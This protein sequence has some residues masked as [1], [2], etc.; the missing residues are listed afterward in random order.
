ML[1]IPEITGSWLKRIKSLYYLTNN[2]TGYLQ[3]KCSPE[4]FSEWVL[5]T[6]ITSFVNISSKSKNSQAE[7]KLKKPK[8][9]V[10]VLETFL[11]S[12]ILVN[13]AFVF[14]EVGSVVYAWTFLLA[15]WHFNHMM[16]VMLRSGGGA[17]CYN[18][19]YI[20]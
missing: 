7:A 9:K 3:P 19:K 11:V 14:A 18:V 12:W 10:S 5:I 4:T 13:Q 1:Q 16:S 8:T 20:R 6:K 17:A 2:Y 15:E